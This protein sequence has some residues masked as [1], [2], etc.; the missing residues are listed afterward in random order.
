MLAYGTVL[1]VTAAGLAAPWSA[2]PAVAA[3]A[4][5]ARP[6]KAERPDKVSAFLA[7]QATGRDILVTG[8]TSA[9]TLTYVRPDGSLRSEVTPAPV[10]VRQRDGSWAGVDYHLVKVGGGYAPR[11]SPA[12]VVFSAGGDGPA[13]TLDNGRRAVDLRWAKSLPAPAI[14]GN[15]AV[16]Q[17][18]DNEQLVLTATSDGFEQSLKLLA[19][20][21]GVPKLRLGFDATGMTMVADGTGG[22]RFVATESGRATST[23]L[24]TMPTPRMY[25]SQVINEEH[26]QIQRV[27]VTLATDTDGTQYVDLSAGKSFLDDPATV[28]PVWIDP[29]VS[30][31][32]RYGDTYVTEADS[33]SHVSD[34]DLRIGNSTNGNIRRS[35]VRFNTT[36][37]IPAGAHVTSAALKLWTN[38]SGTCSARSMAA[39]PITE[40]YTMTSATWA[41]QPSYS[42]SSAYS[43]SSSFAFGNEDLGCANGTGTVPVTNMVQ[44]WVSGKLADYGMLLK[45][46]S[47]TDTTYTKYFCAMNVDA[48]GATSC[49]SSAHYP[50]MSVVY[51]TYP[52][53]PGSVTFS[54]RVAGTTSDSNT[55]GARI[56]STSLTPKFSAKLANADGG[57]V[58]LQVKLSH[59]VN[60]TGEGTGEI[61][62]L[63]STAVTPGS[64]AT[65]AVPAGVLTNNTH[66]MYQTRARVTNGAGGYDY[67]AWTPASLSAT[68]ATKFLLNT[69]TPAEPSIACGAYPAGTWTAQVGA[70]TSCAIDTTAA[71]GAGYY[72]GLDDPSA[73]N[74]AADSSN[75][76]A[77]VT[78]STIA[79][80][81]GWHTLYA[82]SRDT[83]LHLSTGTTAYIFGV[84]AGGVLS[85][86]PGASTAKGVALSASTGSA[87]TGVTY[88]WAAGT[89]GTT[90]TDLPTADVTPA[91]SSTPITAWP[92]TGTAAG[93]LVSFTGYNWNVAATLAAAGEPDGALRVRARFT[94]ASGSTGYSAER[95]FTLAVTTFGQNAATSDLGPG[96]VSLTTGDFQVSA[97]DSSVGGLSIGRTATSL[98]PA[99]ASNGP[100]G[101]F[102]PGWRASLPGADAGAGDA[103]LLDNSVSGS[104]TLQHADGTEAVYVKQSSGAYRGVGGANDG[105]VLT[106]S[107]SITN[108]ADPADTTAYTGW[109]LTDAGGTVTTWT[110]TS[111]GIWTV[112]WIDEPGKEGETAYA[113]DGNGRVTTIL[114]PAPTG[115]T[116]TTG[117]FN[118][119]GCSALRLTYATGTT[120]SSTDEAGWGTYNG[121]LSGVSWT[122]YDPAAATMVTKPVAAYLYDS[123]GHLRAAWDPRDT[124]PLKIRYGYDAAGRI[125]T[126]TPAGLNPWTLSYDNRGRL[127]GVSRNDPANGVATRAVAYDLPVSGLGGAPDVSGTA[128]AG[129]G[130]T[131]DLAYSGAAVFP[132]SHVPAADKA[133]GAYAP[134]AADWPYGS[135]TYA[136]VDGRVVDVA[137]Y[138]ASAWQIDATRYDT[139][140]DEI[141]SLTAGNR[142]Q[143]LSPTADTDPY[144]ASQSSSAARA[145]L[146]ASTSVYDADGV[147]LLSTLG[148]AHP[149]R[150]A[151]GTV[152]S[153]RL[154]TDYTYDAGAPTTDA[155]HLVTR[156]VTGPVALDG[157]VTTAADTR[158]TVTGYNPIDGSSATGNTSGWVLHTPT[159]E[160]TWLGSSASAADLTRQTRYDAAGRVVESR[161]PGGSATDA[162]TTVTTYY[163]TGSNTTYPACGGKPSWAG[164]VC[165]TDP[166][167]A[168]STGYAVPSKA[169]TYNLY[170]QPLTVTETSGAVV[171]T[172]TTGYDGVGRSTGTSLSVTGLPGSAA[173]TATGR[174]YDPAT[175]LP[176]TTTQGS[177]V[178]TSTYDAIGRQASY[179]DADGAV[180]TYGYDL[181]GH[182][183]RFVDVRTTTYTYDS[184]TEHRGLLVGMNAGMDNAPS[185]FT[186]GYDAAGKM[187]VQSYPNGTTA[188]YHFDNTGQPTSLSYQLPTYSGG[189]AGTI[190]F[191]TV[192]NPDGQTVHAQSPLSAQ[193]YTYDNAKRLTEVQDTTDGS[194]VTRRYGFDKQS[195]RTSLASY[196]ATADGGCQT[197]TAAGTSTST[198]DTANRI[199]T[200]GY[201]YDQLGRT[202]TVPAA[203]LA[204]GS[205]ALTV[206]YQDTDM[207][208]SMTQGTAGKTFTLDPARRYRQVV[209]T[210]SGAETR[211]TVNHYANN[212]DS[213][214][215]LTVSADGGATA[216]W[217]RNIIG[218]DGRLA[219]VHGSDAV[220]TL[221]L[222]NL[223]GD[224]VATVPDQVPTATD[225]TG[226]S[227][228]AYFESTEYGTARDGTLNGRYNWLGGAQRSTDAV[229]SLVLMGA[230]LYNPASGRFLTVDPV[231][232]GNQNAYDYPSD[233]INSFDVTGLK[234]HGGFSRHWWGISL[235]LTEWATNRLMR[236]FAAGSGVAWAAAELTSWTGIGGVTGG[237]IAALLAAMGGGI[238]LCDWNDRG[239]GFHYTYPWYGGA[240]WCWAR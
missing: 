16:Y 32:S 13:V 155:Y 97:G 212:S 204:S 18:T 159:T 156:T 168:P 157:S 215:Y 210:T 201:T 120:A 99:A 106:R 165:R 90:W 123:T 188:A 73:P 82:R 5:P 202:L 231:A 192:A 167:G 86:E 191:S 221:E 236:G 84:G 74:L 26:T 33:D 190:E 89:T 132:A 103:V 139:D 100:S 47:E 118:A 41:N 101:V 57:K 71:D 209:D 227:A 39:Y 10:R 183:T 173:V 19:R 207:P 113:R 138:G 170:G 182:T 81:P 224:V 88:Q 175:G 66:V 232:G 205:S 58:T 144:V 216:A 142:A 121:L 229:A 31:V 225:T 95:V 72:W 80:T 180:S 140:G 145:N 131:T 102:G 148:P 211:R 83:A 67:S 222:T 40:N 3:P 62:T 235:Y 219:A 166:G 107:T 92:L 115:V 6:D 51:N 146:L 69:D 141:W 143:A 22:Y 162:D 55:G 87:Y 151:D 218:L 147:D 43:A 181:D 184:G 52:G 214:S 17:L 11:V 124:T 98:V 149:A 200:A 186:A 111:T 34:S 226:A 130:Q 196:A 129:W 164:M 203:G 46:G 195:D 238:W 27:P 54:P 93:P 38:Y 217:A 177:A 128:A 154:R 56:F 75:T 35:L 64:T 68:T 8:E 187:T 234:R 213:P 112:A 1:L 194:C 36:G 78:V 9:T 77:A 44:A 178:L 199:T 223:H 79:T 61:T 12:N 137:G 136:D 48:T 108:P 163:T 4:S 110:R 30:S 37:S 220:A 49:T 28:Y 53:T 20:P 96:T 161:L 59:D 153:I 189:T 176:A 206:A 29:A 104:V 25:S 14:S 239:V 237:A 197:T 117:S 127:A 70:T 150:L 171:R 116:C 172:T 125:A 23:V 24:Y 122:G 105:T 158:T 174:T 152:A 185:T 119:A 160:T 94:T 193:D 65:V 208:V 91:G 42:T 85:P 60:N 134:A 233:P 126:I 15:S 76:G 109:Q 169:Y 135:V 21:A 228:T 7:A 50:T 2:S 63:T 179:T 133:T 198:Y 45:A 114:A 240:F 230:R